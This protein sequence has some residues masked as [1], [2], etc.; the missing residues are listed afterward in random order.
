MGFKVGRVYVLEFAGTGLEGAIVKARSPNVQDLEEVQADEVT[1]QRIREIFFGYL[2]EWNLE[3]ED[4]TPIPATLAAA[5]QELEP[6]ALT[7]IIKEWYRAAKG[8]T[9][10]L[11]PR[12]LRPRSDAG[13]PSPETE[14][15]APSMPMETL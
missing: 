4:G 2:L 14:S 1:E 6:T 10:P 11:D 13:E 15:T 9:A 8:L 7:L 5:L 12:T 3:R